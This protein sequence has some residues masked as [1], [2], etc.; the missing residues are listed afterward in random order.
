MIAFDP[1]GED[2]FR[3]RYPEG[4][5]LNGSITYVSSPEEALSGSHICFIFTE[6]PEIRNLSPHSFKKL[7]HIP[8]VYDGRNLYKPEIMKEAG[9]EY[10]SIGR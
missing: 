6:W 3:K 4:K 9:V 1:V 7:M 5:N 10:Y 2:N 8:L